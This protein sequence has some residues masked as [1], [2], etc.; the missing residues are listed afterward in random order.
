[1]GQ[2]VVSRMQHRGTARRRVL[3]VSA[4]QPLAPTGTD[5]TANGRPVGALGTISGH[6]GLAIARIDRVKDAMDGGIPLLAGDLPV[7]LS[8]P[9]W[10]KF[11]FP[12]HAAGTEGA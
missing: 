4:D 2:E 6:S 9:S 3:L 8:I 5:I 7:E 10:A 12:E 11:T 1:M